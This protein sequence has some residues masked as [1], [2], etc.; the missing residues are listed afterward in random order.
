MA[1]HLVKG[2]F[3]RRRLVQTAVANLLRRVF[4]S[5]A[6]SWARNIASNAPALGSMTLLLVM[7]GLIGLTGFALHNL[8]QTE[9]SQASLL[10][11]YLRDDAAGADVVSLMN[12]LSADR[13]VSTVVYV[14]KE[15]ALKRAQR[16]P[17][18]PELAQAS[19]S[20]PFPASLDV[21]VKNIDD[22]SAIDASVRG[23]V[24][25]DPVYPTSYDRGAYQRIQ[26]V[27]FGAA[28]AGVAF[29]ALLGFVAVM[30]TMNS[31][32]I[33]IHS[34]RDEI[35]IMQLVGAP[36]WMVRG[37]F[38]VEGAITGVLAGAVAGL[39][40]FSLTMT[41]ISLASGTFTQ[42]APGISI[43]VAAVAAA[44]VVLVGLG[45]GSGSSLI[46]LRRHME[47]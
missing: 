46:S 20:N 33:A 47:T 14:T 17:G 31:I 19:D 28:V 9:A 11:V 13:R 30:V 39:V 37:P 26:A 35:T 43:S 38:V 36:R 40:T 41:G 10:H 24:S 6:R 22:V 27:L 3:P 34:R 42:F 4:Q 32:K 25:V 18:L 21:Q 5:A 2:R 8:E 23:D 15:D 12:Q 16:I 7:S 1:G 45:L 29:L 44:V